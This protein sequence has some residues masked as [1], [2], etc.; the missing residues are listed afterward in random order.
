MKLATQIT[1]G[2][3]RRLRRSVGA[4]GSSIPLAITRTFDLRAGFAL[5]HASRTA[6][7]FATTA[8]AN[9]SA[10]DRSGKSSELAGRSNSGSDRRAA[11]RTD[12]GVTRREA[13]IASE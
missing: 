13:G 10:S 7:L 12:S 2:R 8:S 5:I 11:T 6:S 4:L 3:W 9:L 1:V